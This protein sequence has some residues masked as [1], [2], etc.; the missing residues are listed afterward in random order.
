MEQVKTQLKREPRR[1]PTLKLNTNKNS[2]FDFELDDIEIVDYNPHP[3]IKGPIA[4]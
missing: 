3:K 2:I 4:V 1:F